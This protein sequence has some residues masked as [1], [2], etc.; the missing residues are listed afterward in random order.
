MAAVVI[1]IGLPGSGKSTLASH[2]SQRFGLTL[3]DRDR[4]RAELFPDCRFTDEEK[5]AANEAV[6]TELERCCTARESVL[7]DGMTFSRQSERET[8]RALALRYRCRF[9]R[10]WLDCPV[11]LAVQRVKSEIHLA[12]DR[13]AALVK[14]VAARFE[15]PEDAVHLDATLE[16][17]EL[18]RLATEAFT[19]SSQP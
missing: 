18:Q 5:Q 9:L 11:D 6:L 7:V 15:R 17:G 2:L 3:I 1:L 14:E 13:D 8:V 19:R 4:L 10:L 16:P 12:K